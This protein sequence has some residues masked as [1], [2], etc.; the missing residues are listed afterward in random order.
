[1]IGKIVS[2]LIGK[3]VADHTAGLSETQGALIGVAVP[4]VLRRLGPAGMIAAAAGGY[5]WSRH[6]RRKQARA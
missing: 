3:K 5:L 6:S 4:I 1:M 2:A